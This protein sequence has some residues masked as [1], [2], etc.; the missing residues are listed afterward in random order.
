M[1]QTDRLAGPCQWGGGD[2]SQSSEHHLQPR[3][4]HNPPCH[5]LLVRD[6]LPRLH[7]V[8]CINV[9][10]G[11]GVSSHIGAIV[12]FSSCCQT[13]T[14]PETPVLAA[15]CPAD[16]W[17][18]WWSHGRSQ[19]LLTIKQ[20]WTWDK[21]CLKCSSARLRKCPGVTPRHPCDFRPTLPECGGRVCY[22]QWQTDGRLLSQTN[23]WSHL[24]LPGSSLSLVIYQYTIA[25]GQ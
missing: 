14:E 7:P 8:C 2:P 20:I 15:W 22:A 17:C 4:Q 16:T 12:S 9:Y 3:P 5:L 23:K 1:Y 19:R 11:R 24:G 10:P 18:S 25:D 6:K 21:K 13:S